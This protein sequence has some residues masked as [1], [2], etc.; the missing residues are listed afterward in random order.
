MSNIKI[1][2]V[3]PLYNKERY[4]SRCIDSIF[5][6]T[7]KPHEIII[8]NDGSTDSSLEKVLQYASVKVINQINA[9][10]SAAR[11]EGVANSIGTH[12]AFLDADDEWMPTFLEEI[13]SL[14]SKYPDAGLYSSSYTLS[15]KIITEPDNYHP[16]FG[17]TDY[18][19]L[20]LEGRRPG[21][22]STMVVDKNKIPSIKL[23]PENISMG[24]DIFAWVS[25][26]NNN[27]DLAHS[28]KKLAIYHIDISDSLMGEG[29]AK[30]FPYILRGKMG[31]E[32][33]KSSYF[34]SFLK[35]FEIDY[36]KSHLLFGS[37]VTVAKYCFK[38]LSYKTLPY[39]FLALLPKSIFNLRK[40]IK[41]K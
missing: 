37:R 13:S 14:I 3:V 5:Y 32:N 20:Y 24:E 1:S 41:W 6:Q 4:I 25:I 23:F 2:V 27:C 16:I 36:L 19:K 15:K 29:R 18:F 34:Q 31:F 7:F 17:L 40:N 11:N 22:S 33:I 30:P 12:I 38:H 28:S 39:F 9:G 8:I 21:N 26:L 35:H 10:V